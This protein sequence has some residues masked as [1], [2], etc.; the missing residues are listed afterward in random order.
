MSSGDEVYRALR[1][2]STNL[3]GLPASTQNPP[4]VSSGR[5]KTPTMAEVLNL[6]KF[7]VLM[8]NTFLVENC[9]NAER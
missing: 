2:D 5:S 7:D 1:T 8:F 6:A 4:R 3:S 9:E